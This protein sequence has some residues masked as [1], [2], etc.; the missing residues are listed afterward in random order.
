MWLVSALSI[1]IH[2]FI[3][4]KSVNFFRTAGE[5]RESD[6]HSVAAIAV[7]SGLF[8]STQALVWMERPTMLVGTSLLEPLSMAYNFAV[9]VLFLGQIQLVTRRKEDHTCE[10][11]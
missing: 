6:K 8:I 7:L 9:A 11:R 2:L 10:R 3:I 1:F 5:C 4:A